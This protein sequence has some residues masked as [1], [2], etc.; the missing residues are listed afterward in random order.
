[1]AKRVVREMSNNQWSDI[2]IGYSLPDEAYS[3]A[4]LCGGRSAAPENVASDAA[5]A[6]RG[7]V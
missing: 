5:G 3:P 7:G 1:M 6:G 2:L 4:C